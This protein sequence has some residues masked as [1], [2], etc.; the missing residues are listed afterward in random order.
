MDAWRALPQLTTSCRKAEIFCC[1]S[2]MMERA[3]EFKAFLQAEGKAFS[4]KRGVEYSQI[5][6]DLIVKLKYLV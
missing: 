5:N 4:G 2:A 1:L 6:N 3:R